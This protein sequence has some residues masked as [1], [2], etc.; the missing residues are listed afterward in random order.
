MKVDYNIK[1]AL[2]DY[3][4]DHGMTYTE[5]ANM[6]GVSGVAVCKW[7]TKERSGISDV[8]W[9]RGVFPLIKDRLPQDRIFADED[10]E[11]I[12]KSE[13]SQTP[14]KNI[15]SETR[16]VPVPLFA[17]EQLIN[18]DGQ[19]LFIE[20]AT[21]IGNT[22]QVDFV[23]HFGRASN[24]FA[25]SLPEG[26]L[27]NIPP[28]AT[29]FISAGRPPLTGRL[30]FFK[31]ADGVAPQVGIYN[32][33]QKSFQIDIWGVTWGET[34][35]KGKMSELSREVAWIYPVIYYIVKCK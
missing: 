33:D 6:L 22:R 24:S 29:L 15:G 32:F 11:P 17:E 23:Q 14:H 19:S 13:T 31:R 26:A 16:S 9:R 4:D 34:S 8:L 1:K 30:C 10:G 35:I 25:Y 7:M 2:R 27:P 18:Y 20:Y 28:R 3:V 12:Y 21:Q 5:L